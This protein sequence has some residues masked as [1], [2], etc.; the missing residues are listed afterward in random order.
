M[1]AAVV[2]SLRCAFQTNSVRVTK[3]IRRPRLGFEPLEG[4]DCP[5]GFWWTGR[6][7]TSFTGQPGAYS[8]LTGPDRNNLA[9]ATQPPPDGSDLYFDGLIVA[10]NA[11]PP[12]PGP[13]PPAHV[14]NCDWGSGTTKPK[15]L[16]LVSGYA[17]T[18]RVAPLEVET[19]E[20]YSGNIDQASNAGI[21][22]T[23]SMKWTGGVLD[24]SPTTPSTL[25]V[26]GAGAVAEILTRTDSGG[27]AVQTAD[28]LKAEDGAHLKFG[29]GTV[30][31]TAAGGIE[32][33]G[34]GK[35][36]VVTDDT[37]H[38]TLKKPAGG[39]TPIITINP[40]SRYDIQRSSPGTAGKHTVELA[41][42]NNG[43]VLYIDGGI[44][45]TVSG[46]LPGNGPNVSQSSGTTLLTCGST[47]EVKPGGYRLSGGDFNVYVNVNGSRADIDGDMTVNG[48]DARV[49]FS[50]VSID[51]MG[52]FRVR[53]DVNWS[54]GRYF[55]VIGVDGTE[56]KQC[57]WHATG[58]FTV[59][60]GAR[61]SVV[62]FGPIATDDRFRI[63]EGAAIVGTAPNPAGYT[64]DRPG[65]PTTEWFLV[66][67]SPY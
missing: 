49:V 42:Q 65:P 6:F 21:K 25:L 13:N 37:R 44:H 58:Q 43:G 30:E 63:L 36:S 5:A 51:R 3:P 4:R 64:I 22:V 19:F 39:A 16:H 41:V 55:A 10:A 12:P 7:G 34:G 47:L 46:R 1:F 24:S 60:S 35:A 2:R 53:G 15:S 32:L 40:D 23:K 17:G 31:F 9:P 61:V 20:L 62:A 50:G 59:G 54:A 27:N 45:V 67:N 18:V 48:S 33:S 38:L 14:G 26:T 56:Q 52:V 57:L 29:Y 11:P 66:K 8:W 28:T